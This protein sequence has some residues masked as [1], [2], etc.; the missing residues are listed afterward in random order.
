MREAKKLFL[1]I[2]KSNA[3]RKFSFMPILV[4]YCSLQ[5]FEQGDLK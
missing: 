2:L 4:F 5:F 1:F 3:A